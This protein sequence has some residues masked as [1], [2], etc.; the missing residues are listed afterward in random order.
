MEFK[1][2]EIWKLSQK[3]Q[4]VELIVKIRAYEKSAELLKPDQLE[5]KSY[6]WTLQQEHQD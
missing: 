2:E 3:I 6:R 1:A 4:E 5:K